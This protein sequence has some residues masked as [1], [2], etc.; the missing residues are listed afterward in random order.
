MRHLRW[1]ILFLLMGGCAASQAERTPDPAPAPG[2]GPAP[3]SAEVLVPQLVAEGRLALSENR[4]EDAE[5]ALLEATGLA[6]SDPEAQRLLGIVRFH[7]GDLGGA[8][9]AL[10][11]S[12][13]EEVDD[14]TLAL[15]VRT[16]VRRGQLAAPEDLLD[17]RIDEAPE[18]LSLYALRQWVW[19]HQG[20]SRDVISEVRRLLRKDE[21]NVPLMLNLADAYMRLRQIELAEY[22]LDRALQVRE[23]ADVHQALARVAVAKGDRRASLLHLQKAVELRPIFPEALNNLGVA[24]H[25]AGD[26]EAAVQ[27]LR[28]AIAISPAFAEAHVNLGNAYRRMRRYEQAES[29]YRRALDFEP[30]LAAA[31]YNLGILYFEYEGEEMSYERRFT[32]AIESFNRYKELEGADLDKDDPVDKYIAEARQILEELEQSRSEELEAPES[33]EEP[34]GVEEEVGEGAGEAVEDDVV[35]PEE[36][37]LEEPVDDGLDEGVEP[38]SDE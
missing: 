16:Q 28:Q 7:L 21:T 35:A 29:A 30:S 27:V 5:R 34:G 24:Y 3:P 12:Y 19:L 17:A 13:E 14:D 11:R 20:R 36:L 9:A 31:Y 26:D 8:A 38:V 22:I 15:L 4:L 32:Q 33:P 10:G 6:P 23:D 25:W 37:P 1:L 2:P 18:D